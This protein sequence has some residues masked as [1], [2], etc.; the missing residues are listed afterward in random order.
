MSKPTRKLGRPEL[1]GPSLKARAKP[2]VSKIP[3]GVY[4]MTTIEVAEVFS[5]KPSTVL[6]WYEL[7]RFQCLKQ[8]NG[9]CL[10]WHAGDIRAWAESDLQKLRAA[11][12]GK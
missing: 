3:E 5:V 2:D 7:G 8:R 12:E 10:C 11:E 9:S 6:K 4:W 1:R